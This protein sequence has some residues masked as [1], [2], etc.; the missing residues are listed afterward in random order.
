MAGETGDPN[1]TAVVLFH[2]NL[3]GFDSGIAK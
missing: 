1:K 3:W 2:V